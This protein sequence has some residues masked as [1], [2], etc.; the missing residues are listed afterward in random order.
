M[1]GSYTAE[2]FAAD[3]RSVNGGGPDPP[4]AGFVIEASAGAPRFLE[5][6][7]VRWQPAL[8]GTLQLGRTN[9]FFLGGG[10]ALINTLAA[11]AERLGVRTLYEACAQHLE[12][13]GA[14]CTA[15]GVST[16]AGAVT[17]RPRTVVAASGGFEA[18]LDW[19]A[20]H[21]GA[22]AANFAVRGAD[23]D[24]LVLRRLLDA[25]AAR[26]AT[27]AG[28]TRSRSSA[29]SPLRGRDRDADRLAS[30]QRRGE[31]RRRAVLR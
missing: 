3:L 13:D 7:G 26:A 12:F 4:L 14:R 29:R 11:T 25:G 1:V 24:G 19:M 20:A 27:L 10:K 6:S 17:M 30:V 8:H 16:P 2:E 21:W 5:S 23:N 9:R 22:S 18:N 28:S 15:V 31:S